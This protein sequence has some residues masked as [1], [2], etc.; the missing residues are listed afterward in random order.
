MEDNDHSDTPVDWSERLDRL[1]LEN[2]RLFAFVHGGEENG[3]VSKEASRAFFRASVAA[4]HR[5]GIIKP[6]MTGDGVSDAV[7]CTV[8]TQAHHEAR[9]ALLRVQPDLQDALE[10]AVPSKKPGRAR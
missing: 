10:E 3:T 9:L 2:V 4:M 7:L 1:R 8:L 6:Q 5:A